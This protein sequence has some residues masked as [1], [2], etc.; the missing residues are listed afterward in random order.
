MLSNVL[1]IEDDQ[2][3]R[4][5][6]SQL[7]R[8]EG[9]SVSEAGC[10]SDAR[11]LL[12]QERY[13]LAIVD[14]FLPDGSGYEFCEEL[15]KR[16][17]NL[18]VLFMS[19]H[20]RDVQSLTHLINDVGVDCFL[21]KPVLPAEMI[22]YAKA[23]L[24]HGATSSQ[25]ETI[26][27]S[28][29]R[30]KRTGYI[31][32]LIGRLGSIDQLLSDPEPSN[33][34][35]CAKDLRA[36]VHTIRGSA[37][38]YGLEDVSDI[39]GRWE[40]VLMECI[41]G[42][43]NIQHEFDSHMNLYMDA[44]KEA[45][46]G[47]LAAS[48]GSRHMRDSKQTQE[49]ENT[50]QVYSHHRIAVLTTDDGILRDFNGARALYGENVYLCSSEEEI[51][52][53]H[54]VSPFDIVY[55]DIDGSRCSQNLSPLAQR[56][57]ATGHH[58]GILML[59]NHVDFSQ[60]IAAARFGAVNVVEKPVSLEQLVE[61]AND[62]LRL[63]NAEGGRILVVDDDPTILQVVS[64]MLSKDGYDVMTLNSADTLVATMEHYSPDLL[65]CDVMLPKL[66]GLNICRALRM[67]N[68]WRQLPILL[69]TAS[70]DRQMVA[71]VFDVGANDYIQ[72]PILH[73]ELSSRIGNA[74]AHSRRFKNIALTDPLTALP[75]RRAII[76][77]GCRALSQARRRNE[78][79]SIVLIDLDH[80]KAVNDTYGHAAGDAVLV[81][82]SSF[83]KEQLRL[84]DIKGRWGGEEFLIAM[85]Q[86]TR[87][88]ASAKM[89]SLLDLIKE[90]PVVFEGQKISI[91]FKRK[92]KNRSK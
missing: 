56:L 32:N 81:K 6:F 84:E 16:S 63:K 88:E 24:G 51:I 22:G 53:K 28:F 11:E 57:D 23:L 5:S 45:I 15:K 62:S 71:K 18:H 35:Q 54:K 92:K 79:L 13:D 52:R 78:E 21:N 82:F 12:N 50:P 3:L 86:T 37:G 19:A 43:C 10:L 42:H 17:T 9:I 40:H 47:P 76:D 39:A 44:I 83:I 61:M 69:M 70:A 1:I 72:K 26:V 58:P 7:L 64:H 29:I 87:D 49:W 85:P 59:T 66:S 48:R 38:T 91:S 8:E 34:E 65:L 41:Q 30:E 55:V 33:S 46:Q 90:H 74:L 2:L 89:K 68:M 25:D 36:V 75:N 73:E 4:Q 31:R 80:F 60:R 67:D 14:G 20:Y 77:S 27:E